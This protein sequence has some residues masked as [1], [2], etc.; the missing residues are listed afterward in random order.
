MPPALVGGRA[1]SPANNE[2]LDKE[3]FLRPGAGRNTPVRGP[4]SGLCSKSSDDESP[5]LLPAMYPAAAPPAATAPRE[6][7]CLESPCLETPR[8]ES[9]FCDGLPSDWPSNADI[10]AI[11]PPGSTSNP[12][13][14]VEDGPAACIIDGPLLELDGWLKTLPFWLPFWLPRRRRAS[15]THRNNS[16]ANRMAPATE[17]TATPAMAPPESLLLSLDTEVVGVVD[18]DAVD[19][20][21]V[22]EAVNV[23]RG[24]MEGSVTLAHLLSASEV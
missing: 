16:S 5:L 10:R 11:L 20:A 19:A 23:M 4:D 22:A 15:L 17:P 13:G 14:A 8:R 12:C 1:S 24:V 6:T 3:P 2:L 18:A 7:P 21:D 9:P